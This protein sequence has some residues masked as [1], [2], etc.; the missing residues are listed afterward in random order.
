MKKWLPLLVV[1]ICD[2]RILVTASAVAAADHF[3]RGVHWPQSMFGVLVAPWW[4]WLEHVGWLMFEDIFLLLAIRQNLGK[5]L[6]VAERQAKLE[7]VYQTVERHV[8]ERTSELITV[9]KQLL[10]ASRR[11]GMAEIAT[12]VLHNVG[13]ST[14]AL[15]LNV[16]HPMKGL[17]RC[18]I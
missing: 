11:S 17:F 9:H 16:K 1:S 4:R 6:G 2:W 14:A 5:M 18:Q 12:N 15:R 7:S 8:E 10:E 13:C 3:L